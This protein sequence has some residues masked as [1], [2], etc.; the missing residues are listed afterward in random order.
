MCFMPT[1]F[2]V[3]HASPDWNRKD[4]PYH[5]PPG[6]PLSAQGLTEA[7]QAAE[8][9]RPYAVTQIYTSPLERC[10]HTA[11]IA[12]SLSA[13]PVEILDGLREWQPHESHEAVV[14]RIGPVVDRFRQTLLDGL[15]GPIA[16]FTH[17]GPIRA[18]LHHLGVDDASMEALRI[19]DHL[20]PVPPAGVWQVQLHSAAALP[21]LKLVFIPPT[22]ELFDGVW[23]V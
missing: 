7:Q 15:P 16:L 11:R 20:N 17:G 6:P 14:A 13:A 21:E 5:I 2:L 23:K 4:I 8:F 10:H 9:L 22:A 12:A 3:R 1:F 19:Y 18:A